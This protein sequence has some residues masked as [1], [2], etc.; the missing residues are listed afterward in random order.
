MPTRP[1]RVCPKCRQQAPSGQRCPCTPA[2]SGSAWGG[3]STRRWRSMRASKLKADPICQAP[4]CRALAVEVDHVT[5][6]ARGGAR[7]DW[8]N[9]QSLC[10]DCH[11]AK[12][13][14]DARAGRSR[15]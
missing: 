1:P 2:W 4:G 15:G 9:L 14:Q 11:T 12:T 6:L 10:H 8:S 5:P 7:Y 13:A 3:G